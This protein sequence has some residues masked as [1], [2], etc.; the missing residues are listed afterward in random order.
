MN[1]LEL[2][3]ILKDNKK[4]QLFLISVLKKL[5]KK[6]MDFGESNSYIVNIMIEKYNIEK[7]LE[8]PGLS[9]DIC[10]KVVKYI[11][12]KKYTKVVE[13]LKG[14]ENYHGV[15]GSIYG[16]TNKFRDRFQEFILFCI[17]TNKKLKKL[18]E[19]RIK[20]IFCLP[21][22]ISW[23]TIKEIIGTKKSNMDI[24]FSMILD[25]TNCPESN[26]RRNLAKASYIRS[27]NEY[28]NEMHIKDPKNTLCHKDITKKS[29]IKV[30]TADTWYNINGTFF[31]N[32]M[33]YY[34][35]DS[36]AGPSGSVIILYDLV[37]SILGVKDSYK[38]KLFVLCCSIADYI[39]YYHTLTEI[40][41]SFSHE[42]KLGYTIDKDPV[43]FVIKLLKKN[44]LL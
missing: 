39:P 20:K 34:G 7:Y 23:Q 10:I 15:M 16:F 36:I 33:N 30:I 24:Y 8:K 2:S 40:L 1:E 31:Q 11:R 22:T 28:G 5:I 26:F 6:L 12:N 27:S 29:N 41:I 14:A 32:I 19:K 42:I 9:K 17:D 13:L 25:A 37:F 4:V 43:E 44:N 18:I 21:N 3:C 35:R 38:N